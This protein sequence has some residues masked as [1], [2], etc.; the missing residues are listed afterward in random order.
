MLDLAHLTAIHWLHR[1]GALAVV[2]LGSV[3]IRHLWQRTERRPFALWLAV[4]LLGQVA[5][6]VLN[7]VW[8]LPLP[9]AVAHNLVGA[10]L[11]ASVFWQALQ[12][13][14]AGRQVLRARRLAVIPDFAR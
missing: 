8:Q 13:Q 12:W 10:L 6:G 4:L 5:L 9:L 1:L 7:V 14:T 3:W 2:L 11:F